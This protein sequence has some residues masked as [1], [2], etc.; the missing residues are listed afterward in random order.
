MPL[1]QSNRLIEL[2]APHDREAL[3]LR[4]VRIEAR[5]RIEDGGKRV[6]HI[7]FFESGMASILFRSRG[8]DQAEIAVVGRE[9]CS[10]CSVILGSDRTPQA[11]VM[12][13]AGSALMTESEKF[14]SQ[15]DQSR[16]LRRL[17]LH[18]VHT[19]IIQ[20]DETALAASRGT[21][22]Q[23]LSRW[24]LM[25]QDRTDG[26]DIRLTHDIMS[27]MLGCRRAGVTTTIGNLERRGVVARGGR[28]FVKIIDRE[29]LIAICRPYYGAADQEFDR[30]YPSSQLV[31]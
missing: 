3:G 5:F 20:R 12:Q 8:D 13:I 4:P 6:P 30:L 22:E 21:L 18:Y 7:Y 15:M 28:G 1:R 24:L 11:M 9:G 29:G 25:T 19:M 14:I 16:T 2:M 31:S 26:D 23:R 10:S 17:M 27:A